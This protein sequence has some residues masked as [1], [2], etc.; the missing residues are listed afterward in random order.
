VRRLCT[1]RLNRDTRNWWAIQHVLWD[2]VHTEFKWVFYG[3][4]STDWT[5]IL[6]SILCVCAFSLSLARARAC[7][8]WGCGQD[9]SHSRRLAVA[10]FCECT[11]G[12]SDCMNVGGISW[13]LK[14]QRLLKK[15][16]AVRSQSYSFIYYSSSDLSWYCSEVRTVSKALCSYILLVLSLS[17]PCP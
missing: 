1:G 8:L 6:Q 5:I 11:N 14:N 7:K 9:S 12:P 4:L 17:K 10:G 2:V 15:E 13:P 16:P 3:L